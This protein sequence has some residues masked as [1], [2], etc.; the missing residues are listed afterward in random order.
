MFV[1]DRIPIA[2]LRLVE[3]LNRR[4]G[5]AE[6]YALEVRRHL[7]PEGAPPI[8]EVSRRGISATNRPKPGRSQLPTMTLEEW[9]ERFRTRHGASRLEIAQAVTRWVTKRGRVFVTKSGN[10]SVGLQIPGT[11]FGRYP[12]FIKPNGRSAV[13][14]SYLLLRPDYADDDFRAGIGKRMLEIVGDNGRYGGPTGDVTTN[15]EAV[16]SEEIRERFFGEVDSLIE[17]MENIGEHQ[18]TD[19]Q[20]LQGE[21]ATELEL[22]KLKLAYS[23]IQRS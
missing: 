15:L 14:F 20:H 22:S 2:L 11:G 12:L 8:L 7:G 10:P 23:N 21:K 9:E 4:L 5:T 17:R 19:R 6:T 13:T 1:L 3:F 16:A 18:A